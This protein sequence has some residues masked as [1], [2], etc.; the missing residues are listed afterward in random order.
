MLVPQKMNC[1]PIATLTLLIGEN[2]PSSLTESIS[3]ASACPLFSYFPNQRQQQKTT[4]SSLLVLQA[5]HVFHGSHTPTIALLD[6]YITPLAEPRQRRD[7]DSIL[8]RRRSHSLF[9]FRI[10]V[11]FFQNS[12]LSIF[13]RNTLIEIRWTIHHGSSLIPVTHEWTRWNSL[14]LTWKYFGRPFVSLPFLK[15]RSAYRP[16]RI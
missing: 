14:E 7:N 1:H 5:F 6:L 9:H 10:V 11:K 16:P 2:T 12:F 4:C 13:L 8:Y 15:N 3:L